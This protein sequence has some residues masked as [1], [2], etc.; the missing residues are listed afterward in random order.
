MASFRPLVI[1]LWAAFLVAC[2]KTEIAPQKISK[3]LVLVSVAPYQLFV[4]R[5]GGERLEVLSIVPPGANA[6]TYEPTPR[7]MHSLKAGKVW[8]RIGEPCE[9]PLIA[10]FK[11][12]WR[13]VDLQTSVDEPLDHD[14]HFWMSPTL[15]K[16]Q[17]RLITQTLS[18]E[19]PEYKQEFEANLE[20]LISDLDML[21]VEIRVAM[22]P[23][24]DAAFLVSHPSFG[25]FCRDY[26]LEQLSVEI[27][28]KDPRPKELQSLMNRIKEKRPKVAIALPEMN[29]KG[30]QFLAKELSLPLSVI[31][32]YSHE[33]FDMMHIF[34]GLMRDAP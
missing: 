17:A 34:L 27:E 8:F 21:D 32:P 24:K 6:H 15:V 33:Y 10:L 26:S 18:E 16:T 12:R 28:G 5:I 20:L 23:L 4:E 2:G 31:D 9:R 14:R 22:A 13:I 11:D 19:W 30:V 3:P 29:N 25:Y 1:F 7:Q